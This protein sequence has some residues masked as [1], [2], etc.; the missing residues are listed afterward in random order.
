MSQTTKISEHDRHINCHRCQ[1]SGLVVATVY[2]HAPGQRFAGWQCPKC[3]TGYLQSLRQGLDDAPGIL[4]TR[5]EIE[6]GGE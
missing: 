6:H 5:D 1:Y 2:E 4:E 3:Q